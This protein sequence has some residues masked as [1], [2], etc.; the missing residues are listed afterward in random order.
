MTLET[1]LK[2]CHDYMVVMDTNCFENYSETRVLSPY[3]SCNKCHTFFSDRKNESGLPIGSYFIT[4]SVFHEIIQQR[5]NDYNDTK[6]ELE[7]ISR[8]LNIKVDIKDNID[9]ESELKDYLDG[10]CIQILPHPDNEIFPKIIQRALQKRLPFK[11]IGE[12]KN[13]KASD[14]GFKD[15][16]LWESILNYNLEKER[17]GKVFL[18]TAN[19]KDFPERYL[20]EEWK[21]SHPLVELK[22]FSRWEDFIEEEKLLFPELVAQNNVDFSQ[23]FELFKDNDSDIVELLNHKKKIT[24]RVDSTIV[25]IE[26]DVKK[27]D[28]TIFTAKYYYD[29]KINEPTLYDPDELKDLEV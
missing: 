25:E 26:A 18:L 15:V 9:F 1:G 4:E 23:V 16:L 3:C 20:L 27:A 24:G 13:Q 7:K 22:I 2:F 11:P 28:G 10:F 12:G 17:I 6:A 21:E 5:I 29:I 14:K 19:E 8:K